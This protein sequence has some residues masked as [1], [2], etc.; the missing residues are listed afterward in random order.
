MELMTAAVLLSAIAT[1]GFLV[2]K[3]LDRKY[4]TKPNQ[5]LIDN[6][7]FLESVANTLK[8]IINARIER[9]NKTE[10]HINSITSRIGRLEDSSID[11]AL[12]R[13]D[14]KEF[15]K[16]TANL[17]VAIDK[18]LTGLHLGEILGDKHKEVIEIG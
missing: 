5:E 17:F 10:E 8:V 2:N 4:G 6:V 11:Y 15:K 16:H 9:E 3:Y 12:A 1:I 13:E 18:K 7:K 14:L